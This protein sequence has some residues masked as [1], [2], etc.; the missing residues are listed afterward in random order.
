[1]DRP[2]S[3]IFGEQTIRRRRATVAAMMAIPVIRS[4]GCIGFLVLRSGI[5]LAASRFARRRPRWKMLLAH[6]SPQ[7]VETRASVFS[8]RSA[9]QNIRG[10]HC[11]CFV[12]KS[13]SCLIESAPRSWRNCAAC[14]RG[15]KERCPT[16]ASFPSACPRSMRICRRAAFPAGRCTRSRPQARRHARRLRLPRGPARPHAASRAGAARHPP[17]ALARFGRPYG[18]GLA[19]SA[20]IRPA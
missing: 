17:R 6:S 1:M 7:S 2:F 4:S 13:G 19:R 9:R 8:S 5:S 15:W 3:L 14:C 20:S 18:H 10:L 12:L 11:S 16:R